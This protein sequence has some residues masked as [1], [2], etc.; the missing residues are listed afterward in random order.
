[1]NDLIKKGKKVFAFTVVL[2]T[3]VWSIGIGA[4]ALPLAANAATSGDLIK[5][6]G[7]AV[8]Y[9]GSDAKRYVFPYQAAY[10]SWYT[11][12]GTVQTM[13]D[14]DLVAI[15][16]G[17][18][19]T[20][21]PGKL[22]Q[23]VSMDTPWA[24]MDPKVYAVSKGGVL[25]WVK[26]AA[27]ATSIWG[28]AWEGQ[29][30]AVPESL[31]TNYT[32]GTEINNASDYSLATQLAVATINEDKGLTGAGGGV[33]ISLASDTPMSA[34][35]PNN[36]ANVH[37]T[38]L[39]LTAGPAGATVTGLK[40][41]RSGLGADANI[42][43][44]KLFVD[45]IQRGTSQSL[46][47]L[48]QAT[49]SLSSNPI[50]IAAGATQKV[51]IAA[52]IVVLPV[53]FD[54]HILG[55]ANSADV[56]TTAVVGGTFPVNGNVM[57]LVNT[58]IGT[59]TVTA[60]P[61]NPTHGGNVDA[62][63]VGYRFSQVKITAGAVE[64]V[65][66]DQLTVLKNGTA[67][68]TD[69][70]N[71]VLYN[72]TS[73][74]VLG[75][76]TTLDGNGRVV[77]SNLNIQIAKGGNVLLSVKADV[78]GGSGRDLGFDVHD[79]TAFTMMIKGA[80]YNFGIT[81]AGLNNFCVAAFTDFTCPRQDINQGYLTVSKSPSAPATGKI[82]VGA[83]AVPVMAFD[84]VVAGEPVNVTRTVMNYTTTG[85]TVGKFT[86]WTLYKADGTVLAGPK[87][88]DATIL[89]IIGTD[90][91]TFTDSYTLPVGTT[92]VWVKVDVSSTGVALDTVRLD[93]AAGQITAK[94]ANSGKTTW[95]T[96]AG[97]L[98]PPATGILG[99]VQ[100]L[101]GPALN[102]TTAATPIAGT[103][104]AN[105]QDQA[106]AYIDLDAS[107]GGENIRV[108]Q[109]I[110]TDT[111]GGGATLPELINLELWGDPDNT[112]ATAENIRLT[113]SNSTATNGA[114]VTFTFQTPIIV[115]KTATSRLTLKADVDGTLIAGGETHTYNVAAAGVV[116]TGKDTGNNA[117]LLFAGAGQAQ[118]LQANGRLTVA[119][120]AD[121]PVA[122]QLVSS[123][124][125]NS[126]MKYKFSA[127]WEPVDVTTIPFFVGIQVAYP[128]H[129]GNVGRVYLYVDGVLTGNTAGYTLNPTTGMGNIVLNS[130][131]LV[132]PKDGYK[133][134]EFRIDVSPKDQ[135]NPDADSSGTVTIGTDEFYFGIGDSSGDG[136]QWGGAGNYSI[137]AN[138]QSSG[139]TIPQANI[140]DLGTGAGNVWGSNAYTIHKGI[141]TVSLNSGSPSGTQTAGIGKDVLKLNFVA[142]GDDIT[143][144]ELENQKSGTA[145]VAGP[146][147]AKWCNDAATVT[148]WDFIGAGN[149]LSGPLNTTTMGTF[150]NTLQI[151]A[152]STL[153]VKLNGDTTGA[154]NPNTLQ[155]TLAGGT[156]NVSG[157]IWA[158]SS[159]ATVDLTTTKNLPVNGGAMS[160]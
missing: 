112:D 66:L 82:G 103:I 44:V 30:V 101:Q 84:Y 149:W 35:I 40:V 60:G 4:L 131:T 32:I 94:G 54:Q 18:N 117:A 3:I 95:T 92:T 134:V 137:I 145:V 64:P 111:I 61:L 83:S 16:F 155:Y 27:L 9:Y 124:T 8:Y 73:G 130:G 118:T 80:T 99:N 105:A 74:A 133:N 114:T 151:G 88:R 75:T 59:A 13:T 47:S 123:S 146:A 76:A 41:T 136:T 89:D 31:L 113:T 29:I 23:V 109:V 48:H 6:T 33:T 129:I 90:T 150:A 14:A 108:S 100:T 110:V 119:K 97:P 50:V 22:L 135:V 154:V 144:I 21:H 53:T 143:I 37:F 86:N 77:F 147:N 138:G 45:G 157:V 2:T 156:W 55:I 78:A 96:S 132:I 34:S 26:T 58:N 128:G 62:D 28:A 85:A 158:D 139:V 12:F 49:F 127:T 87:N 11:G 17:G 102:V 140:D 126:V 141:L 125:N 120:A 10:T 51:V 152:G 107:G 7:T 121:L 81:P 70:K 142:T 25:H 39:N 42:A 72:D 43:A 148:Y 20:V 79:G 24:V 71:I 68:N 1:M 106:F 56:T 153:V 91:I 15:P 63:A 122:A 65:V 52:D 67:A 38:Y 93:M 69:I 19:V 98:V 5:G 115:S 160:Y 46:G 116:A 159:L 36:A 104:V 57:S